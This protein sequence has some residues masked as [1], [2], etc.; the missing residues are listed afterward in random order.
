M[1]TYLKSAGMLSL[2]YVISKEIWLRAFKRATRYH[3][4][5][6][7]KTVIFESWR[8]EKKSDILGS[9]LILLSKS[10]SNLPEGH[11]IY[12]VKRGLNGF[13][14]ESFLDLQL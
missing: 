6:G 3:R 4:S 9:R 12:L 8:S 5:M 14:V 2:K 1:I 11:S 10:E 7:C 13:R